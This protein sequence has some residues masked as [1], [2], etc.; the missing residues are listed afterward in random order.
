[1]IYATI[2]DIE[3]RFPAELIILAADEDTGLRDDARIDNAL[4]DGSRE[5]RAILKA[6][7]TA[8]DFERLDDDSLA[9]LKVFTIDIA[10]YRVALAFSRSNDRIKER[11][12]AAIKRLEAIAYGKG[13]LS[14][15]GGS[16][17]T[18]GDLGGSTISPNEVVIDAPERIFTRDRTRGL[19]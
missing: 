3:E 4:D 5:V 10:L 2:T 11:Y 8:E 9:M 19:R 18:D 6:R 17:D 1:M 12:D 7:Y 14:F 13:G 15:T 16:G